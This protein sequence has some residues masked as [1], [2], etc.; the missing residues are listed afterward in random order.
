[1]AGFIKKKMTSTLSKLESNKKSNPGL[2]DELDKKISALKERIKIFEDPRATQSLALAKMIPVL[3]V[4]EERLDRAEFVC[5]D[6]YSLADSLYTCTLARLAMVG[7]AEELLRT[8]PR[9]GKWWAA[10]QA[11]PSFKKASFVSFGLGEVMMK[12]MCAIL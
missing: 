6:S 10:M 9:L 5:G 2:S 4:L 8:R 1:M 12:R 3:D 11:R 7:L